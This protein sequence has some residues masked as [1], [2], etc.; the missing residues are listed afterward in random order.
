MIENIR[1]YSQHTLI[2]IVVEGLPA[3]VDS[4]RAHKVAMLT[5]GITLALLYLHH[6]L[7]ALGFVVGFVCDDK[8]KEVVDKVNA[9]YSAKRSLLEQFV[10]FGGGSFL[11]LYTMPTSLVIATLYYSAQWGASLCRYHKKAN[12]T[13]VP[14]SNEPQHAEG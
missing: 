6:N 1:L 10:F 2:G 7:F 8:V 4:A 11:A 3:L 13:P 9:A 12:A 14:H 5:F